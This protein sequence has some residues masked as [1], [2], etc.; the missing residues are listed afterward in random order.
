MWSW[1]QG[2]ARRRGPGAQTLGRGTCA[3]ADGTPVRGWFEGAE[4]LAFGAPHTGA[5]VAADAEPLPDWWTG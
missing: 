4:I 5:S 1:G 3:A 2:Q